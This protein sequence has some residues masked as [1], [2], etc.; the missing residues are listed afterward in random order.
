MNIIFGND[1]FRVKRVVIRIDI[2]TYI[3][4][5]VFIKL[6]IIII[7]FEKYTFLCRFHLHTKFSNHITNF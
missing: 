7:N 3:K 5:I 4:F 1:K 2:I 6:V